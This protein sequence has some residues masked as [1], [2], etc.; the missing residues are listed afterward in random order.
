[1][2]QDPMP[3]ASFWSDLERAQ[4]YLDA[5]AERMLDPDDPEILAWW[6]GKDS[7]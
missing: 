7:K 4:A 3:A 1:M 6:L 2:S 5:C